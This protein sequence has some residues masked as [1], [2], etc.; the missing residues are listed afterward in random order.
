MIR[1][2]ISSILCIALIGLICYSAVALFCLV[3]IMGGK[4]PL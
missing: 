4:I 3:F 1:G 2:I